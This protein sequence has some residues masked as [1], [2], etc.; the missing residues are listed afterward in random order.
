MVE[1]NQIVEVKMIITALPNEI[2]KELKIPEG[3]CF[4]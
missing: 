1:E 3:N 4:I 2:Q